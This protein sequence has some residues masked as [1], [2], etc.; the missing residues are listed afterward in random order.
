MEASNLSDSEQ[1][2]SNM[3]QTEA[4]PFKENKMHSH[5]GEKQVSNSNMW[6]VNSVLMIL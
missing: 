2:I 4:H 6:A 5:S 3:C 1:I